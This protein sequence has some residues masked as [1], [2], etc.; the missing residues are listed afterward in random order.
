M[1]LAKPPLLSMI[2]SL[3]RMFIGLLLSIR[4]SES[5]LATSEAVPVTLLPNSSTLPLPARTFFRVKK[6]PGTLS[7]GTI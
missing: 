7:C 6:V 1:Y 3:A 2:R 5:A 4:I